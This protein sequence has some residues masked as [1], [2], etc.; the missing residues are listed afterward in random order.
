MATRKKADAAVEAVETK[1][2]KPA[3]TEAELEERKRQQTL[4]RKAYGDVTAAL[5]EKY[6]DEFYAMLAHEQERLGIEVKR[7]RT[8][9][10]IAAAKEQARIERENRLAEKQAAREAREQEKIDAMIA[11]QEAKLAALR[12]KSTMGQIQSLER[13]LN[14]VV[15][16]DA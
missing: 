5:R 6:R 15:T 13:A 10:E 1:P 7:R 16:A 4:A 9:A 2:A 11:K 8:P 14:T 12:E 3:P